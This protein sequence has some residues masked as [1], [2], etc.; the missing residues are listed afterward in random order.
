MASV[1]L[2]HKCIPEA[3]LTI[4]SE[5]Q[6]YESPLLGGIIAGGWKEMEDWTSKKMDFENWI[7][8]AF[9]KFNIFHDRQDT[10]KIDKVYSQIVSGVNYWIS[11]QLLP[12]G[13]SYWLQVYEPLFISATAPP[14]KILSLIQC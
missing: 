9:D 13:D 7:K 1:R 12:K 4:S 6:E 10:F 3:L 14:I 8:Y 2:I 5:K 11:F